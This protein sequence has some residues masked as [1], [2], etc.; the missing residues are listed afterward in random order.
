MRPDS[1]DMENEIDALLGAAPTALLD[2]QRRRQLRSAN[3]AAVSG[4]DTRPELLVRREMHRM[5]YRY[6]LH[7]RDLPGRPDLVLPRYRVAIFVHG[8][9]WHQH[10]AC[11]KGVVPATNIDFWTTKLTRNIQ[12]DEENRR[13]LTELGWTPVVFWECEVRNSDQVARQM[14]RLLPERCKP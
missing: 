7:A 9:F 2:E 13:A 4:R 10:K 12:R 8:C 14:N 1:A 6:R 5:G 3:M 11:A